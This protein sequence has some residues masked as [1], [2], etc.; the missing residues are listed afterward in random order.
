M[1]VTVIIPTALRQY[2]GGNSELQLEAETAGEALERLTSTH[3]ELRKHLFNEANALRNFVNVYVNDEDIRHA[4]NLETPVRDGDTLMI[5]PSIAGGA[6]IEEEVNAPELPTLSHQ[7]ITRYSRHLIMPEVG[8]EGQRRLKNAS[9]L[10]IGTG[11]LGAPLGMYLAAAGVGRLG[12]VDFD[13]VEES[14]LQRQIVHGTRDV[15]RPKIESARDRLSDIN[16]L[17]KIETHETRLTSEN[18]L[19]LFRDY[20]IIVDGTDNFPTR[21]LVNDACVLTGKPNVYGS[22]FRF[23]GQASVF[24]A[25]RGA[26]YRCLYPEPPPPGLVPSCAEGGV[27]G[28]LPG[29]VGAIQANETI[30]LILGGGEPLINRLLLF[31]AWKMRFRELKLRKDPACPIC[32]ENATIKRLIDYEEF[33]GLKPQPTIAG[34]TISGE[35]PMQEMTAT[36]LKRLLD[37]GAD[38]QIIDVREPHEH[39]IARIPQTHLIPLAQVVNRMSEIDPQR[40]T[41]VH[42]K[43]GG[44]SAKAINALQEAG[45][46]GK[47]INLKGGITAWSNEVDPNVAKY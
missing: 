33:C 5:V 34:Q 24:W 43:M 40:E 39:D 37:S 46:T 30:K 8:M 36:E 47:L 42:C 3:A 4:N 29:I 13:V 7:E 2:A 26:C 9:V 10:M 28:V 41:V 21:Y 19:D 35:Q 14:N 20:D 22:I 11:G 6:T 44:R 17:I 32:G 16:P 1:P 15:G 12:L 18:A 45:F 31:D 25:E 38:V 27:L 23:E